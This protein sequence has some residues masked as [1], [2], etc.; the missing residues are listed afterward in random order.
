MVILMRIWLEW[1][2]LDKR[3]FVFCISF[4]KK[5]VLLLTRVTLIEAFFVGSVVDIALL[6]SL[7]VI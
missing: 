3:R 2:H 7:V 6:S 5:C 4:K 1:H